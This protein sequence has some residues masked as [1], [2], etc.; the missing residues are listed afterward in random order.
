MCQ[1]MFGHQRCSY[2]LQRSLLRYKKQVD[3]LT[4]KEILG[5]TQLEFLGS[6]RWCSDTS[7]V[8]KSQS[9]QIVAHGVL[10]F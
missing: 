6:V 3:V 10:S 4:L 2:N 8:A 9:Y 5:L 7:R 1:T